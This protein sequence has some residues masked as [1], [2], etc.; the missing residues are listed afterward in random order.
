MPTA[1]AEQN[2]E[3]AV[4][5][6]RYELLEDIGRGGQACT[7]RAHDRE[8]DE[9]VAVKELDLETAAD[10]KAVELFEREGQVLGALTH[11]GI[12]RYIDSFSLEG[13][14]GAGIRFFLVQEFVPGRS[15]Q[16]CIDAGELFDQGQARAFL[17]EAF[18]ILAYLHGKS[19]PVIHRDIKPSN[20]LVRPDGRLALVDFGAVQQI[21][22]GSVGGETVVGTSGFL[23]PEQLMGRACEASDL[24]ALAATVV[25]AMSGEHPSDLPVRE[26]RLQYHHIL[27]VS[28]PLES[29]LDR[30]LAP[31]VE[32]RFQT[33]AEAKA[34]LDA[35]ASGAQSSALARPVNSALSN[36]E[37]RLFDEGRVTLRAS[38]KQLS[39]HIEPKRD[40]YMLLAAIL[41]LALGLALVVLLP[42]QFKLQ[43]LGALIAL[44][45]V[46][47]PVDN[48]T[49]AVD[50]Y[51]DRKR[52][53]LE[54]TLMGF[55]WSKEGR[56]RDLHS[57][58]IVDGD[59]SNE[60]VLSE[61][62]RDHEFGQWLG[63]SAK[64][65]IQSAVNDFLNGEA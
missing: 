15:L 45:A 56:T 33:V 55:S 43:V 18:D 49:H 57:L 41:G 12:P 27:R 58:S 48:W 37:T 30:M 32:E 24:Y 50:L 61:G 11:P 35:I 2:D 14:D 31:F 60:L 64:E 20:I 8:R 10:W 7:Y 9:T 59:V 42:E 4:L 19:P 63:V 23:P 3:K 17:A 44:A 51:I 47:I 65:T 25:Y 6:D 54:H 29:F 22:Q 13:T 40:L 5:R 21:I 39:V 1:S 46:V 38:P 26:M 52:F 28:A 36:T 53:R 34:A 62:T 16:A